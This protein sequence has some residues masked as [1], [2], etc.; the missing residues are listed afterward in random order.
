MEC[1]G[2]CIWRDMG[3][4]N[5]FDKVIDLEKVLYCEEYEEF[6]KNLDNGR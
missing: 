2:N 3:Y 1:H 6:S 4:C 5:Y